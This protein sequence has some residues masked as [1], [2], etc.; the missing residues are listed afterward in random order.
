ML[1]VLPLGHAPAAQ[2]VLGGICLLFLIAWSVRER[3]RMLDGV[4]R[5]LMFAMLFWMGL[6]LASAA[7]S[8][9][10]EL[11]LELALRTT[12]VPTL[13]GLL[14]FRLAAD[15]RSRRIVAIGSCIGFT[16]M[17]LAGIYALAAGL[18]D[19]GGADLGMNASWLARWYPG[20]GLASSFVLLAM[21]LVFWFWRERMVVRAAPWL[22][23]LLFVTG[24]LTVNRMFWPV[25]LICAG[26][27]FLCLSGRALMRRPALFWGS[28]AAL[29]A[30]GLIL[31]LGVTLLRYGF[32]LDAAEIAQA[33]DHLLTDPRF[34]IW[35][36][37]M[38]CNLSHNPF[39]GVGYGKKVVSDVYATCLAADV[40]SGM[41]LN[42]RSHP[43]N[44][45]FSIWLQTGGL[46]IA[47][48]VALVG[49]AAHAA[50]RYL[51]SR[52]HARVA[53]AAALT[54]ICAA[55]LKNLTDDFYDAAFAA[56]FWV[57]FGLMLGCARTYDEQEDHA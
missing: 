35:S 19:A 21:L 16:V 2:A 6:S 1:A 47:G 56:M 13:L 48:F 24:A 39:I 46:G 53:G 9:E 18:T 25:L 42:G 45:L 37:W 10:H 31:V 36:A 26:M 20:P 40:A 49:T 51:R 38:N 55:L 34:R 32:S 14:A 54:L 17:C 11:S 8:A 44:L 23:G 27:L 28:L 5:P 3:W 12:C 22:L 57:Y 7:W 33:R 41:D 43:H 29:F 15:G 50:I 30:G 4:P 52:T